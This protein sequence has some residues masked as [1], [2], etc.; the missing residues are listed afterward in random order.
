VTTVDATTDQETLASEQA[1]TVSVPA[2][3][4]PTRTALLRVTVISV[5]ALVAMALVFGVFLL[6][7]GPVANTWYTTRQ[8]RLASDFKA[9]GTHAQTGHAIGILQIPSL[10]TNVVVAEGDSVGQLRSGPAHQHGTPMP[11]GVG[12]S[13]ILGHSSAWGAP[14]AHLD[15]LSP[16]Q[17]VLVQVPN[18]E[19]I[20]QNIA[21]KVISVARVG[22]DDVAPFEPSTDH[23]LTLVTGAGGR[24]SDD[25]LAVTA[26]SGHTGKVTASDSARAGVPSDSKQRNSDIL[27]ALVVFAGA[28]VLGFALRRR[29]HRAAVLAIVVPL[30]VLGLLS[31][32]LAVDAALPPLR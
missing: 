4:H 30:V 22:A 3:Q 31:T 9:A 19:G 7:E 21:F 18:S 6:F 23:R 5:L 15:K 20:R 8:H 14:F 16:G 26:V 12:N 29:Y 1:P 25:R 32:L 10:G 24:Y 17:Y 27:L 13:V 11:G 2:K 28:I